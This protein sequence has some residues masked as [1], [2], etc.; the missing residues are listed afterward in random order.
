MATLIGAVDQGEVVAAES[1]VDTKGHERI[2]V[3]CSGF[4]H[5][6]P[7]QYPVCKGGD[8]NS[9]DII[10]NVTNGKTFY[11]MGYCVA[12]EVGAA[13]AFWSIQTSVSQVTNLPF[14]KYIRGLL[15]AGNTTSM[16][17]AVPIM[18]L[19]GSTAIEVVHGMGAGKCALTIW[20]YEE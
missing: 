8:W 4:Q 5:G 16:A 19:D 2:L 7:L 6:N 10:Y 13:T 20:G 18:V 9:G 3:E 14:D 17:S 12:A 15:I 11:L 1:R